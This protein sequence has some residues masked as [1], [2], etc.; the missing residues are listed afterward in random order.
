[1]TFLTQP[2]FLFK[3]KDGNTNVR[4]EPVKLKNTLAVSMRA[5]M[6]GRYSQRSSWTRRREAI[7]S[8]QGASSYPH[9]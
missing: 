3:S 7:S 9:G 2:R 4:P 8:F 6:C 5:R 1:M